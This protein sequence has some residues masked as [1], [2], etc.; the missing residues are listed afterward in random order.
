MR[1]T[2][3]K[4][5]TKYIIGRLATLQKTWKWCSKCEDLSRREYANLMFNI[6]NINVNVEYDFKG[7]NT[8][9]LLTPK[10]N[11]EKEM[12][13]QCDHHILGSNWCSIWSK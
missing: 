1:H 11:R 2:F 7:H 5:N 8:L 10:L 13:L 6:L 3:S 4:Y 12:M 9:S